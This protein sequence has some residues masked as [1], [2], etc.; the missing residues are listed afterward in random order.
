ML[1]LGLGSKG[2]CLAALGVVIALASACD[3]AEKEKARMAE[4]QRK[5]DESVSKI[6]SAAAEK[7]VA[8]Q[9]KIDELET[10]L[11]EAGAQAKA[12]AQ[13]DVSKAKSEEDK[14]A[15][16]ATEALKKARAAYKDSE[17]HELATLL[18]ELDEVRANAESAPPKVKTQLDQALRDIA[19]K[20]EAVKK[21]IDAFDAAT[22]ETL[23]A[24][25]AKADQALT[26]LKQA[27]LAAQAKLK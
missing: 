4:I 12:E 3:D 7:I 20:K 27:I 8:A 10:L 13:D 6:Q 17:R 14:L 18:K 25:K 15:A 24:A 22:S 19:P 21:D 26:S 16:E 2:R 5:A 1:N 11:V 23:K 9:R